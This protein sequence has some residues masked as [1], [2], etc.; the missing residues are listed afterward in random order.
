MA[1]HRGRDVRLD[2]KGIDVARILLD[3]HASGAGVDQ[4]VDAVTTAAAA[5]AP[6][7][8]P[9]AT[10]APAPAPTFGSG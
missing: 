5:G 8:V 4:A 6:A 9:A 2:A 7:P 1:G 3:A 10:P